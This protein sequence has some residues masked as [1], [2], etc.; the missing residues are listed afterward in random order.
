VSTDIHLQRQS[1][2]LWYPDVY[3]CFQVPDHILHPFLDEPLAFE[4][5]LVR[6]IR[7]ASC[8][9][10]RDRRGGRGRGRGREGWREEVRKRGRRGYSR[11]ITNQLSSGVSEHI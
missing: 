8:D 7:L 10:Q 4:M 11:N 9:G 2:T 1:G 3:D 6:L 5:N